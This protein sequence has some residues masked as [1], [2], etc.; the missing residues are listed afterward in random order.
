MEPLGINRKWTQNLGSSFSAVLPVSLIRSQQQ[1]GNMVVLPFFSSGDLKYCIPKTFFVKTFA[2]QK[3]TF[4]KMPRNWDTVPRPIV[5]LK[6]LKS[7]TF[8]L[9]QKNDKGQKIPRKHVFH[10]CMLFKH[11]AIFEQSAQWDFYLKT[12]LMLSL[13]D[14]MAR[15]FIYFLDKRCEAVFHF[16]CKPQSDV[17]TLHT[18]LTEAEASHKEILV[19]IV[20]F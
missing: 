13:W 11:E 5:L 7:W 9:S 12:T 18:L 14:F 20:L 10:S 16:H 17:E 19:E 6:S 1:L 2:T 3:E 15:G 4:D 8:N